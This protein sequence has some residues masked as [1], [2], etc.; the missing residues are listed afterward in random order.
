MVSRARQRKKLFAFSRFF[1]SRCAGGLCGQNESGRPARLWYTHHPRNTRSGEDA[2]R[3][4]LTAGRCRALS[5][6]CKWT[7]LRRSM[8]STYKTPAARVWQAVVCP[9]RV[10]RSAAMLFDNSVAENGASKVGRRSLSPTWA[11][12]V[13]SMGVS[14]RTQ[15]DAFARGQTERDPFTI[16]FNVQFRETAL[17][18][19]KSLRR[20]ELRRRL[21]RPPRA[22]G[23]L[24]AQFSRR[25]AGI[26]K[27]FQRLPDGALVT[28]G[29][30]GAGDPRLCWVEPSA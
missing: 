26:V 16:L 23:Q 15:D 28:C 5:R 9:D 3:P 18:C 24:G 17:S 10:S 25:R 6:G 29:A 1:I 4:R 7:R 2:R 13:R 21:A 22:R 20:H 27:R 14:W 12:G 11:A 30:P 8:A 19:R